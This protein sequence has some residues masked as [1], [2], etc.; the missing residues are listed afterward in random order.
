[1]LP[2][3]G[4]TCTCVVPH[5]SSLLCCSL[6]L[7]GSLAKKKLGAWWGGC[8]WGWAE[9]NGFTAGWVGCRAKYYMVRRRRGGRLSGEEEEAFSFGAAEL[10]D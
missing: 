4:L 10:L 3:G 5:P 8:G 9:L 6:I 2:E 7:L 1:M